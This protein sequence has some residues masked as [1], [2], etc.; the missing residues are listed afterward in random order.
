MKVREA[1][2]HL[3]DYNPDDD[4]VIVWWDKDWMDNTDSELQLTDEQW[5]EVTD[6]FDGDAEFQIGL[7][8]DQI[9]EIAREVMEDN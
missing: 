6:K 1:L 3:S 4:L 7:V 9:E 2:R 5:E 8:A